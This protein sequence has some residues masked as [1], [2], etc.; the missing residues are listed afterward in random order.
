M[1]EYLHCVELSKIVG[2]FPKGLDSIIRLSASTI[3]KKDPFISGFDMLSRSIKPE[4]GNILVPPATRM[5][6]LGLS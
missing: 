3:C 1:D 5:S 2:N 4:K 6:F